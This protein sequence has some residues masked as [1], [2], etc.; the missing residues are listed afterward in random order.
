MVFT[1]CIVLTIALFGT[2]SAMS[3]SEVNKATKDELMSIKGVGEAKANAII[4][5]RPFKSMQ[6]LDDVKGVG[7]VLL[8]NIKS[9][10]YKKSASSSSS[11]SKAKIDKYKD[12]EDEPKRKKVN[13][14][15]FEK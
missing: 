5:A 13:V 10:T 12:V 14:I 2:L 3:L 1:R 6:E 9:D 15:H 11:S 7:D 8:A 4:S